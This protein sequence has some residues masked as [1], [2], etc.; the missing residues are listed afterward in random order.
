MNISITGAGMGGLSAAIHLSALGFDVSVYEKN[1]KPGGKMNELTED[2]FRFDLGPSVLTMPFILEE[3]FEFTGRKLGDY[4]QIEKID[5]ICRNFFRD[6][7]Y[8]DTSSNIN[9]TARQIGEISKHDQDVLISYFQYARKMYENSAGVFLFN[10][11]HEIMRLISMGSPAMALTPFKIDAFK[12]MHGRNSLYFEHENIIKIFDRYATYNGSSPY[13]APAT[14]NMIAHVEIGM[15]TYYIRGGMYRLA[16]ALSSL[17][18]ELGVKIHYNTPIDEIIIEN[19]SAGGI[20][21][22]GERIQSD[23][24]VAGTDVVYTLNELI[25][26]NNNGAKKYSKLE[27]SI[28][29]MLFLWGVERKSSEMAL[30]NVFFSDDYESE[31]NTIFEKKLPPE[32]PT[33]Y[34]SISSKMDKDHAPDGFENWYVLINM[35]YIENDLDWEDEKSKMK[36]KVIDRLKDNGIDIREKIVYEHAISPADLEKMYN[37]NRGSIYGISSNNRMSAFK[38]HPNRS[39]DNKNLYFCGGSVHPGGG[40]PLTLLSGR[41]ASLLIAEREGMEFKGVER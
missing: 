6:S 38:R 22:D 1:S 33:T 41:H 14:L 12:T 4:L 7:G 19:G 21:I 16:E 39:R 18:N 15:G 9:K 31:F 10:P 5:P 28:S 13:L 32:D 36:E 30:H 23:Y 29:G 25:K 37:T 17:C 40:V 24:V 11:I 8:I 27:P 20:I 26:V 3:I 35:P 2:Q 34:V